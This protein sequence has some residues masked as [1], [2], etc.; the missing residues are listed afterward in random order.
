M[1]E[2]NSLIHQT[3]SRRFLWAYLLLAFLVMLGLHIGL[4]WQFE[5]SAD[6][7]LWLALAFL[8]MFVGTTLLH[9]VC[10]TRPFNHLLETLDSLQP[11]ETMNQ[12]PDHHSHETY[13]VFKT[14][15]ELQ[16]QRAELQ[17]YIENLQS[18][19]EQKVAHRTETL[20]ESLRAETIKNQAKFG[21]IMAVSHEIRTPIN[22]IIG[23]TNMILEKSMNNDHKQCLLM[24]QDAAQSLIRTT[25]DILDFSK[26]EAHKLELKSAPFDLISMIKS[27]L[28]LLTERARAKEIALF[29]CIMSDV[30]QQ[31]QGDAGRI[32][33]VLLNILS[34]AME[35]TTADTVALQ[36]SCR[37]ENAEHIDLIFEIYDTGI[38]LAP[39]AISKLFELDSG[40]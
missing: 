14:V 8:T 15:H 9:H 10:V 38:D 33:Q 3:L 27:C 32:R 28:D 20:T 21:F 4:S 7:D 29:S 34:N 23:L 17:T 22:G 25:N 18:D 24:I 31:I 39:D 12:Q 1:K 37:H 35:L 13:A 5:S 16:A 6:A 19:F 2:S 11:N 30:P 40:Y 36:V 26:L